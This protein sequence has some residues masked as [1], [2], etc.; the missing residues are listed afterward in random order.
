MCTQ[1]H[2]QRDRTHNKRP[3]GSVVL[4][5]VP[6]PF[7]RDEELKC[8]VCRRRWSCHKRQDVEPPP[9]R[10]WCVLV[11]IW[12]HRRM[13]EPSPQ[14][15]KVGIFY[16]FFCMT[17]T[18]CSRRKYRPPLL[19]SPRF[20]FSGSG[21]SE[22][23]FPRQLI[24]TWAA[25]GNNCSSSSMCFYASLGFCSRSVR[26]KKEKTDIKSCAEKCLGNVSVCL[27][28]SKQLVLL[29]GP[30]KGSDIGRKFDSN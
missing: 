12:S 26:A 10:P 29:W 23:T 14:L 6:P 17:L 9:P 1:R 25:E 4:P 5:L 21:A 27:R 8:L 30:G 15:R 19:H 22:R 20:Y 28:R 16:L 11:H 2:A 13:C 3:L 7:F 24:V 18:R